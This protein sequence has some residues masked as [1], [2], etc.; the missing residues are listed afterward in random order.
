MS[1]A[2][3]FA[4]MPE[5]MASSPGY[6]LPLAPGMWSANP[7]TGLVTLTEAA[8]ARLINPDPIDKWY[9]LDPEPLAR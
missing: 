8:L 1:T 6:G 5:D 2:A 4:M 9:L 3:V 7:D